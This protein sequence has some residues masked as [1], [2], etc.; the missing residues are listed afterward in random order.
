MTRSTR[1][2]LAAF[3]LPLSL[4]QAQRAN[5]APPIAADG[6]KQHLTRADYGKWETAGGVTL[7]PNGKWFAYTISRASGGSELHYQMVSD[8][9]SR[10]VRGGSGAEFTA[11]GRYLIYSV[12]PSAE[13]GEGRGGRGGRGGRAGGAAASGDSRSHLVILDLQSGTQTS[14]PEAQGYSL[15]GDQRFMALRRSSSGNRSSRGADLVIHAIAGDRADLTLGGVAD[16]AWSPNGAALAMTIDVDGRGGNGVQ[17]LDASTGTL[18]ALETGEAR[19]SDLLWR[20]KSDDLLAYRSRTDTAYADTGFVV[21]AWRGA[22]NPATKV[23]VYDFGVDR[24]FPQGMRVSPYQFPQWNDDGSAIFVG[25]GSR[26]ERP[27][28]RGTGGTGDRGPGPANVEVWHAKDVRQYTQQ[29]LQ[30]AQERTRTQLAVWHIDANKFVRL[31]DDSMPGVNLSINQRVAITTD[32]APY[33]RDG[34]FGRPYRDVFRVDLMTG[35]RSK[36]ITRIAG[37]AR[38]SPE[39]R[40][41]AYS[42]NGQWMMLD[43]STGK[44][45]N[46]TGTLKVPFMN[47]EDDHPAAERS[48]YG[49]AGWTTGEKSVVIYDRYDLWRVNVD[50]TD[51]VRLTKGREDS[52]VYRRVTLDNDERTIDLAKPMY[53]SATGDVSKKSGYARLSSGAV[54]RLVWLD[55]QVTGLRKAD[56]SDVL[57]YQRQAYEDSPDWYV[58]AKLDGAKQMTHTNA[59]Q[60]Q[61]YWGKQELFTYK[62]KS[63]QQLQA[64]LTY[65]ADYRPGVKYPMVVYFYEKLSD[66]FHQYVAPSDRAVYSTQVFSQEGYFV[67]RP[68]ITFRPRDPGVSALECVTAAVNSV[69]AR[70]LIDPKKVGTM[71]HSWGGYESAYFATHS[72]GVFAASIAGAPLTDLISFYGYTSGNTGAAETGHFEVGQERMQ[73]PFWED[74]QAYIR[75][76]SVFAIDKL[77]IPLLLEEGDMDGNVNP[78]Q[79]QELYNFARRLGKN[80]VY[81][82]YNGEN[83]NLAQRNNQMDYQQRQLEWFNHYLKGEPAAKWITDGESYAERQKLLRASSGGGAGS[84]APPPSAPPA[85]GRGGRGG[86]GS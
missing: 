8:D 41:A 37:Q 36:I 62:N 35:A 17:V 28:D 3:C 69:V 76:S 2:A 70:G 54:E 5:T 84:N 39:G 38:L 75:N 60:D 22:S 63:G 50:G 56:S 65:P 15:S 86:R 42:Q 57:A 18:R 21:L 16:Y 9:S 58:G 4:L 52:T 78:F 34:M 82:V 73:V 27:A 29:R 10:T 59:F 31:A 80:V 44:P 14:I 71:G 20:R 30:A 45:A 46:L 33:Q 51:P 66:G 11:N 6:G 13:G 72:N 12:N 25:I 74:P 55:K 47:M 1:A 53:L 81:L 23:R 68:D 43:L 64:M 24:S 19:Y 48:P 83:H 26:E 32:A 79:S 40:Y 67:L 61:Y 85:G 7:S 49:L 77:D